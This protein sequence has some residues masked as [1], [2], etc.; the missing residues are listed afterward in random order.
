MLILILWYNTHKY[1]CLW[2]LPYFRKKN[3][4]SFFFWKATIKTFEKA[5]YLWQIR[6]DIV[7]LFFMKSLDYYN[8]KCN[9]AKCTSCKSELVAQYW[10]YTTRRYEYPKARTTQVVRVIFRSGLSHLFELY[11][12]FVSQNKILSGNGNRYYYTN[13][14]NRRSH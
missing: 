11:A 3:V 4:L 13:K 1:G 8:V 2:R 6:G 10:F 9:F 5:T 12:Y 7:P 14:V